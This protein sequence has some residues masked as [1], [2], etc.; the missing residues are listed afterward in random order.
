MAKRKPKKTSDKVL[1]ELTSCANVDKHEEEITELLDILGHT[2]ALVTDETLLSD[3][4][5]DD[6]KLDRI[7]RLA[8]KR[9]GS[10][11]LL[12]HVA[13]EVR[14]VMTAKNKVNN[15]GKKRDIS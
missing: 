7:R 3:F 8:K 14:K 5:L 12:V 15:K 4:P 9:F 11:V 1:F 13:E 10:H 6:V 2:E